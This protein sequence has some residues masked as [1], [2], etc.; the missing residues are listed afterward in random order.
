MDTDPTTT[1]INHAAM[2][3]VSST[4]RLLMYKR[5][6]VVPNAMCCCSKLFRMVALDTIRRKQECNGHMRIYRAIFI[7]DHEGENGSSPSTFGIENV[8]TSRKP[9]GED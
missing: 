4:L 7:I 8:V 3:I 2:P 1:S 9:S 6:L 5:D